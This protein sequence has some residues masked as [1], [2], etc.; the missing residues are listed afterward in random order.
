MNRPYRRIPSGIVDTIRIVMV[1][2]GLALP[3]FGAQLGRGKQRPYREPAVMIGK[4]R[5]IR[6]SSIYL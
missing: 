1:G 3:S 4:G 2:A 5:V 6:T